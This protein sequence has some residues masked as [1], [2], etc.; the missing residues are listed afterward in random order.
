MKS[1]ARALV[2]AVAIVFGGHASEALASE[3]PP[4]TP[5]HR[6]DCAERCLTE[7]NC[8]IKS[9]NW[10]QPK[11]KSDCLKQ[12]KSIRKKCYQACDEKPAAD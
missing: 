9:C 2:I 3:S 12:C 5:D 6:D 11:T 8:C 10:V 4:T 7:Y 1:G